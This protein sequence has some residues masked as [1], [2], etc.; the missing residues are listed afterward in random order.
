M[1]GI[2]FVGGR[3][4]QTQSTKCGF[5]VFPAQDNGSQIQGLEGAFGV[6]KTGGGIGSIDATDITASCGHLTKVTVGCLVMQWEGSTWLR[7]FGTQDRELGED[8]VWVDDSACFDP[9]EMRLKRSSPGGGDFH[10]TFQV[11]CI[12]ESSVNDSKMPE[13]L[14][15]PSKGRVV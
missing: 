11:E 15:V 14:C 5:S 2:T 12:A 13:L 4:S 8:G 7:W 6:G 3:L 10:E 1:R 9:E